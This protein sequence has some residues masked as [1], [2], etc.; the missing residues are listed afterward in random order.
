MSVSDSLLP[1]LYRTVLGL[2]RRRGAITLSRIN[3]RLFPKGQHF[4][5]SSG[6]RFFM[7]PD[8]HFFGYLVG[9]ESYISAEIR[10]IVRPG[11]TCFDIGANIGYFSYQMAAICGANGLVAAYEPDEANFAWLTRN[12][13]LARAAGRRI[14][15]VKAAVSADGGRR[16]VVHGAESTLHTTVAADAD[17]AD[18][19]A[20]VS[21]D[22][23]MA[24]LG[25]TGPVKL[26]K[27]DVEGHEP[28][29]LRGM[30]AGVQASLFR[31]AIV[32]LSPGPQAA[33]VQAI[34]DSWGDAVAAL[35]T[36]NGKEWVRG[37]ATDITARSD[38]LIDFA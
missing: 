32:E 3:H 33:E 26:V 8:P 18:A 22:G 30:T 2:T 13:E 16:K 23:E 4:R 38:A 24:R 35:R 21:I 7:P 36:W 25:L 14:E 10:R 37:R 19:V 6:D 29:V 31:H 12:V 15:A 34:L 20:A 5:L 27:V 17:D 28:G 1:A 11:D 9:H